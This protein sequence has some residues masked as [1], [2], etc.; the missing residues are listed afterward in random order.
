[1]AHPLKHDE[2]STKTFGG[3]SADYLAIHNWFDESK[4]LF[5][6]SGIVRF[7][8]TPRAFSWQKG[9]SASRSRTTTVSKCRS[10]TLPSNT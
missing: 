10:A 7:D 3:K 9:S 2:S 5:V 8:I 6:T 1:M 4:A